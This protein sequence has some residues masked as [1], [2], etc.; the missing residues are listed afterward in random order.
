MNLR[1]FVLVLFFGLFMGGVVKM[2][3]MNKYGSNPKKM[4]HGT[5]S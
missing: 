1:A 4:L 3:Q 2:V 5:G